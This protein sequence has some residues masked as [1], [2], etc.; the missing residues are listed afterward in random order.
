MAFLFGCFFFPSMK[1]HFLVL[2][3]LKLFLG[4][5]ILSLE[6]KS[7]LGSNLKLTSTCTMTI[8]G[9]HGIMAHIP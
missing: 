4:G 6:K 9:E 5:A 7:Q 1:L 3:E 2:E 8:Y